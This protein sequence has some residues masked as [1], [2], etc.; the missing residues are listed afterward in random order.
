MKPNKLESDSQSGS[1][2]ADLL[3]VMALSARVG[4]NPQRKWAYEDR[5]LNSGENLHSSLG[6]RAQE[7]ED[8]GLGL[9]CCLGL[10][11]LPNAKTGFLGRCV[12]LLAAASPSRHALHEEVVGWWCISI[13]GIANEVC[14]VSMT[15]EGGIY[16]EGGI[17]TKGASASSASVS[18]LH[19]ITRSAH[20]PCKN[21]TLTRSST[22]DQSGESLPF[23]TTFCE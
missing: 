8:E 10:R 20:S 23:R 7:S 4:V 17:Y 18:C 15:A 22:L 21:F 9:I 14:G 12:L 11:S 19:T 3:R 5:F 2:P 16:S 1:E 6:D 13:H